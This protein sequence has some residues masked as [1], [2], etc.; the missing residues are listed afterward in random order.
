MERVSSLKS[1]LVLIKI[2][3]LLGPTLM[4]LFNP[5]Y[6]PKDLVSKNNHIGVRA[7]TRV[8]GNAIQSLTPSGPILGLSGKQ[9][10]GCLPRN[11]YFF[12]L[13]CNILH[14]LENILMFKLYAVIFLGPSAF[15]TQKPFFF[16]KSLTPFWMS[17]NVP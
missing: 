16:L 4:T 15:E 3:A 7:S 10:T 17:G 2:P 13:G 8:W 1:L 6:L 9:D 14:L 12:L 11:K 5:I